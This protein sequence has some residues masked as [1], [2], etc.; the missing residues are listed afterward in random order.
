MSI[1]DPILIRRDHKRG[2]WWLSQ[3]NETFY[4]ENRQ[5]RLWLY[6]KDAIAWAQES[7]GQDVYLE[8]ETGGIKLSSDIGETAFPGNNN[9]TFTVLEAKKIDELVLIYSSNTDNLTLG[10]VISVDPFQ[11]TSVIRFQFKKDLAQY[12]TQK[13]KKRDK[14]MRLEL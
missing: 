11:G 9:Y 2:H 8:T 12:E 13:F 10:R 14:Q 5:L 6:A 4:D 7:L 1:T 3:G